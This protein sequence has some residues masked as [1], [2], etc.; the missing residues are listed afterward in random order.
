[1]TAE[2]YMPECGCQVEIMRVAFKSAESKDVVSQGDCL[3]SILQG[4]CKLNMHCSPQIIMPNW[5]TLGMKCICSQSSHICELKYET[6]YGLVG[7]PPY[8]LPF[9][10]AGTS[11]D[12]ASARPKRRV[13]S[14]NGKEPESLSD[15]M[16]QILPPP[17]RNKLIFI[18][19]VVWGLLL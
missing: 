16:D 4:S 6:C 17:Q 10:W 3:L 8:S 14:R 11:S 9:L 15:Y 7:A 5:N 19:T 1:M 18:V 12:P 13:R 2:S